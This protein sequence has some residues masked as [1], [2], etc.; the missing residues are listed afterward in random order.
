MKR[1]SIIFIL[2][3]NVLSAMLAMVSCSSGVNTPQRQVPYDGTITTGTI[4]TNKAPVQVLGTTAT[5]LAGAGLSEP[6]GGISLPSGGDKV[7]SVQLDL[8]PSK[9]V[10]LPGEQVQMTVTLTNTSEGD[11]EPLVISPFPPK[12][13][14]VPAGSF[15]GPAVPPNINPAL[16][17]G[18]VKTFPAGSGEKTLAK[19]EKATFGLKWDQK[20]EN[21]KQA[22]PGWYYY[23][24]SY[25]ANQESSGPGGGISGGR[26]RAFLIQ[27]PQGAM[28]KVI[29]VNQ[30]CTVSDLPFLVN[31]ETKLID[32]ALT[33]EE[34]ELNETGATFYATMT[35]PDNPVSGYNGPE[36]HGHIPL[37]SQYAVDGIVKDARAPNSQFLDNEVDFRWGASADDP[38]YLD[39][40]P[41]DAKNLTFTI[42]DI[43]PDWKGP[44]EF[45]IS[46]R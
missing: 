1:L 37:A 28:Q 20:D 36:W 7:Y 41:A 42:P 6:P 35:S 19:G 13:S 40:V 12:I 27:Y 15:S 30:S 46:L 21:G 22:S 2:F 9:T 44:W 23:E 4:M 39:P 11:V 3:V 16:A 17:S 32:V 38:N 25:S 33:L 26:D 29:E 5:N 31:G 8:A 45:N 34:V 14:L 43:G 18:A 24:F 10:Y